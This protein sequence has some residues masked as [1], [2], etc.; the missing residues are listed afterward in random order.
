MNLKIHNI[1]S[2]LFIFPQ[3]GDQEK[4]LMVRNADKKTASM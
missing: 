3:I 1:F 2:I 4:R